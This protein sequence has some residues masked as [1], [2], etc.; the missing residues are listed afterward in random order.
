MHGSSREVPW[1]GDVIEIDFGGH[2]NFDWSHENFDNGVKAGCKAAEDTLR[3][4]DAGYFKR[5]LKRRK[6]GGAAS[7][8]SRR[9]GTA[10]E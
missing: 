5:K 3:K 4:Y 10:A 6:I 9:S 7:W 1:L 2:T 8:T